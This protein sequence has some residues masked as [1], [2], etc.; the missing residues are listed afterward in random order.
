MEIPSSQKVKFDTL[1][2]RANYSN[3]T[4]YSIDAAGLR[5]HSEDLKTAQQVNVAGAQG[6]GDERRPDG[7]YTKELEQQ[8]QLLSSKPSGALGRLAK[9]TGGFLVENTNNLSAGLVRMQRDRFTYYLVGYQPTPGTG[10]R[11][12]EPALGMARRAEL[13]ESIAVS[14]WWANVSRAFANN[15]VLTPLRFSAAR[16]RCC[17]SLG[18]RRSRPR[19]RRLAAST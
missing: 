12:V 11:P 15:P 8:E 17:S 9:K 16:I 2:G 5:V 10:R 4:I 6:V 18:S 3:I 19:S 1:I 13:T 7:P 14:M